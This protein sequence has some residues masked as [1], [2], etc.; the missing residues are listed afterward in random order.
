MKVRG[1]HKMRIALRD[2]HPTMWHKQRLWL[3]CGHLLVCDDTVAPRVTDL[4][5]MIKCLRCAPVWG[6]AKEGKR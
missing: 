2:R 5:L 1:G 3:S 6:K 4:D